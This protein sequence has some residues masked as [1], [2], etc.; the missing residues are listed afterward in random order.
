MDLRT[1]FHIPWTDGLI[2]GLGLITIL[3]FRNTAHKVR[4]GYVAF[5]TVAILLLAIAFRYYAAGDMIACWAFL[6]L[7]VALTAFTKTLAQRLMSLNKN[8][9]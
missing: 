4:L 2:V 7:A 1:I 8:R 3:V 6:V 9:H 5:G